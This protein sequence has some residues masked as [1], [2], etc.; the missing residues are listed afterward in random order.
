MF[1]VND[2][3]AGLDIMRTWVPTACWL[4]ACLCVPL[5]SS[6][7]AQSPR[8]QVSVR[9]LSIPAK[10]VHAYQQGVECLAKK[11]AA[12]SLAHFQHAITEFAGYYEA[13][14]AIGAADLILWRI[15]EAE[16]AFRK[17]IEVS[18][19]RYAH[20]FLALGAIL[21]DRKEFVEAESLARKGLELNPDSSTGHYYQGLAL[22]G[23]NHLQEAEKTV[24]EAVRIKANF[25]EAQ[26]LL[27][28]IHGREKDFRALVNDLDEYLQSVPSGPI[29]DRAKAVRDSALLM[30]SESQSATAITQPLN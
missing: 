18:G 8:Y 24:R 21:D 1:R 11:D 26:L 4:I 23:L 14:D 7:Q 30:L 3:A 22:F 16:V 19:G 2:S 9:Q 28:D 10:A 15:P 27:A 6:A 12:G 29:S 5:R 20:P 13:Y 25:P 17:S